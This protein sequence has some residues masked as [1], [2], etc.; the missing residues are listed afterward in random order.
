MERCFRKWAV[1]AIVKLPDPVL[2]GIRL[3]YP[4]YVGH[5][6]FDLLVWQRDPV[7]LQMIDYR[8]FDVVGTSDEV[9]GD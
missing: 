4:C 3:H 9:G 1:S 8:Q 7:M 2:L 6:L 5:E